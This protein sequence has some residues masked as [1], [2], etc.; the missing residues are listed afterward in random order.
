MRA[1]LSVIVP[2][3]NAAAELPT[4]LGGLME[5]IEAGLIRELIVSDGG[6]TDATA[7]IADEVGALWC[8]GPA[9]RGGQLRRGAEFAQGDWLL[10]LH[11]DTGLPA[12]WTGAVLAQMGDGRPGYFRLAFD[13]GGAA[14]RI[15]ANWANLRSRWAHLP[16]GDQGL[17][18]SRGEYDAVGGFDDIPLM[19]DVAIARRLGRRL[20]MMPMTIKTGAGR[21]LRDG[22]VRRGARN[23]WL[24]ARYL[25][26][27]SP[28]D[29]QRRY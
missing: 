8:A 9:S 21:Y 18:I 27:A 14:P 7:Q 13:A 24:L 19:E 2:T 6:S 10:F 29:L 1:R 5:G 4:L 16:Y 3:Y 15:V 20:C 28:E 26:G 25:G 22:W 12:G 11:A 23:L 17:L